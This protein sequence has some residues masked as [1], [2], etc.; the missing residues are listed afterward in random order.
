MGEHWHMGSVG[1]VG[2]L[3]PIVNRPA[4]SSA[5]ADGRFPI[6]CSLTSC[7]TEQHPGSNQRGP[8]FRAPAGRLKIGRRLKP[9]LHSVTMNLCDHALPAFAVQGTVFCCTSFSSN[10][11]L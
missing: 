7:P 8:M 1:Q 3:Q 6:G 5:T 11:Q 10:K 2:N 9:A 4:R